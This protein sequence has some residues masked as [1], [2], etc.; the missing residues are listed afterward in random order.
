[1]TS[2]K[3]GYDSL[4]KRA[5]GPPQQ[6]AQFLQAFDPQTANLLRLESIEPRGTEL[7]DVLPTWYHRIADIVAQA[8]MKMRGA[9]RELLLLHVEVQRAKQRHFGQRMLDYYTLLRR[10]EGL[11]VLPYAVLLYPDSPALGYTT[12]EER[13]QGRTVAS[14]TYFQVS[15]P[16]LD[17]Q[18]YAATDNA[19]ARALASAMRLPG[20]EE[21]R[22]GL[23]RVAVS[24]ILGALGHGTMGEDAAAALWALVHTYLPY[25]LER[26]DEVDVEWDEEDATMVQ[27]L[28]Q[29]W[30]ADVEAR[31][32]A[33]GALRAK[34]AWL[35]ED[36]AKRFGALSPEVAARIDTID[37]EGELDAMKG[38]LDA[39]SSP[40]ELFA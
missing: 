9:E 10:V 24:A 6:L 34:R 35:K 3:I 40:N 30:L 15:L 27:Q 17:G 20:S 13:F 23:Y 32:E 12:Y 21:E 5:L 38:R 25:R 14:L 11:P 29:K 16:A 39:V 31:G 8:E 19:L 22:Q 4:Y 26:P 2:E 7:F 33:L 28:D 36:I 1:M 37:S 18:T